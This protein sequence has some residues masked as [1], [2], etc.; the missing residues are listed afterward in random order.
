MRRRETSAKITHTERLTDWAVD[1]RPSDSRLSGNAADDDDSTAIIPGTQLS[2]HLLQHPDVCCKYSARPM[3]AVSL[4]QL[5][6]MFGTSICYESYDYYC[7][8]HVLLLLCCCCCTYTSYLR[9]L[10]ALLVLFI[11]LQ[12]TIYSTSTTVWC[13]YCYNY[14]CCAAGAVV[15]VRTGS[16][17]IRT[18]T[19]VGRTT[20]A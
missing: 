7:L 13:S 14:C 15:D 2:M 10:R 17:A 9:L 8:L 5:V 11:E 4:Q 18:A 16:A 19:A 12:G 6:K 3:T 1:G 20:S